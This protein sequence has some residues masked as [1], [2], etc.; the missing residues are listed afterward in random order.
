MKKNVSSAAFL[1]VFCTT[2]FFSCKKDDAVP[3]PTIVKQWTVALSAKNENPVPA[4]RTET[5]TALLMLMS[6]NSLTYTITVNGLATGDAFTAAHLHVGDVITSGAVILPLSPVFS[7]GV[8]TGT[9]TNLRTTLVDSLKDD[10]NEIYFN[11]HTTQVGSG[12]LRGQLNTNVEMAADVALS[13]ANEPTPVTTTTTGVATFRLTSAK[14][15]YTKFVITNLETGDAMTAAH[16]HKGAV[17]VN[18][19][20]IVPIYGSAAEFGTVKI[21]TITDDALFASLKTDAIYANAHSTNKGGG[22]VRGQIR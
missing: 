14:K 19:P 22:I 10:N 6:D 3:A 15:L 11:A 16:I 1:C 13:G 4:G 12:L 9:T 17:G 5:G 2:I 21:I 7:G 18:G 20:V 8:G